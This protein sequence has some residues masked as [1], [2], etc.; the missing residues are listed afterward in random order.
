MLTLHMSE[1]CTAEAPGW[2]NAPC[3]SFASYSTRVTRSSSYSVYIY[4]YIYIKWESY[5]GTSTTKPY[6]DDDGCCCCCCCYY[7]FYIII[8]H[9]LHSH[10]H[11]DLNHS[12]SKLTQHDLHLFLNPRRP[13][14]PP[15]KYIFPSY[16][17]LATLLFS[18]LPPSLFKPTA[19]FQTHRHLLFSNLPPSFKHTAI[20]QPYRRRGGR[21]RDQKSV[22]GYFTLEKIFTSPGP[23]PTPI[24]LSIMRNPWAHQGL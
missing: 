17:Q 2:G 23:N 4:I 15:P 1:Y 8:T 19:F 9:S 11:C 20:F 13:H 18:N 7:F 10:I 14:L 3:C 22:G 24:L 16:S 6:D 21:S 12:C 5:V